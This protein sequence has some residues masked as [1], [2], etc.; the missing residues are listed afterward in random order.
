MQ[1]TEAGME[2]TP[3]YSSRVEVRLQSGSEEG[4]EQGASV[5]RRTV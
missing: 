1:R 3:H 2:E 4:S 5:A